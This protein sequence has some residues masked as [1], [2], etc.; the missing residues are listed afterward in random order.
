M[1]FEE[2]FDFFF[3]SLDDDRPGLSKKEREEEGN[4]KG[5]DKKEE[6]IRSRPQ[7]NVPPSSAAPARSGNLAV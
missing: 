1:S 5:G 7:N 3:G 2:P 6:K 4:V